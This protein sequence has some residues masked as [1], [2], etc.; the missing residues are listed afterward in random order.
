M[1]EPSLKLGNDEIKVRE[2][3]KSAHRLIK[4]TA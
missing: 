2:S 1:N 3:P 4:K